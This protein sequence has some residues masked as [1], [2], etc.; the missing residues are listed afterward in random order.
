MSR[1][2]LRRTPTRFASGSR[3]TS[4]ASSSAT[5]TATA[6]AWRPPTSRS[7]RRPP[8]E[9]RVLSRGHFAHLF[10][11]PPGTCANCHAQ[12]VAGTF[13]SRRLRSLRRP[14]RA[15]DV[16]LTFS[17]HFEVLEGSRAF[18]GVK[19][20]GGPSG[21]GFV[22]FD[23]VLARARRVRAEACARARPRRR[24]RRGCAAADLVERARASTAR[25]ARETRRQWR[26]GRP[27]RPRTQVVA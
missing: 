16:S 4:P 24:A 20:A 13:R 6:G 27:L 8:A 7:G 10:R 14:Y 9:P 3:R 23:G 2:K 11:T 5:S 12:T 19:V 18:G 17:A 1:R 21:R 15:G 22:A 26:P 25:G